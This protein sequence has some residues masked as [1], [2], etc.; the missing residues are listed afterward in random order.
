MKQNHGC[1]DADQKAFVIYYIMRIDGQTSL[2]ARRSAV[3]NLGVVRFCSP[4]AAAYLF[5]SRVPL[6]PTASLTIHISRS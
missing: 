5:L 6:L 1:D 4:T 2:N 3:L